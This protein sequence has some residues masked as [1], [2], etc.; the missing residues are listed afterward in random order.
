[1]GAMG[2]CFG[3][4][5]L[6][7]VLWPI[8]MGAMW[9]IGHYECYGPLLGGAMGHCY[10]CYGLLWATTMGCLLWVLWATAMGA[11]GQCFKSYG[12]LYVLWATAMGAIGHCYG[13]L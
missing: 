12:L 4:Y 11:M 9:A 5:G 3:C 10:V 13:P 7:C 8:A 1:M 6:L 2:H